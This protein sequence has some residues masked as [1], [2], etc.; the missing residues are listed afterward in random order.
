M[1]LVLHYIRQSKSDAARELLLL[2]SRP[3]NDDDDD[4]DHK[5]PLFTQLTQFWRIL[6]DASRM[7]H[8]NQS[9]TTFSELTESYLLTTEQ[10]TL[11][12]CCAAVF[13]HLAVDTRIVAFDS[14]LRLLMD[15]MASRVCQSGYAT[16]QYVLQMLLEAH[17]S[18]A[19]TKTTEKPAPPPPP[20]PTPPAIVFESTAS[21]SASVSSDCSVSAAAGPLSMD[22]N[23]ANL[24]LMQTD[25][26]KILVRIYLGK[27][28][29]FDVKLLAAQTT[30]VATD[31]KRREQFQYMRQNLM[32]IFEHHQSYDVWTTTT[33]TDKSDRTNKR[34]KQQFGILYFAARPSYLDIMF[35][36]TELNSAT[37]TTDDIELTIVKFQVDNKFKIYFFNLIE[38]YFLG[39]FGWWPIDTRHFTGDYLLFGGKCS[40][41]WTGQFY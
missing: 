18:S 5:T 34:N 37:A 9:V 20:Q 16:G 8:T 2:M 1:C 28:K 11:R 13:V 39:S 32:A 36:M 35:P 22:N 7:R 17:L 15:H 4:D 29:S 31:S 23:S 19:A 10:S 14:L 38:S 3:S 41:L 26:M 27:L 25:S 30:G 40:G 6:F 33:T 24:Y 21:S 12:T